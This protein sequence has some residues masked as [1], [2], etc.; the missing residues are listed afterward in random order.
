MQLNLTI[1]ATMGLAKS[2]LRNVT[3]VN[4]RTSEMTINC[5]LLG[6]NTSIIMQ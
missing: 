4:D 6:I 3:L 2:D 1:T 5:T